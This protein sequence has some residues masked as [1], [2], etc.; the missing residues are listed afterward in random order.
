VTAT[1]GVDS[2]KSV[3]ATITACASCSI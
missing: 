2:T 3:S 1:S